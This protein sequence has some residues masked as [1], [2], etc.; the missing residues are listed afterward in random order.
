MLIGIVVT[1]NKFIAN[2]VVTGDKF[3]TSITENSGQGE[4]ASVKRFIAGGDTGDKHS[5][6]NLRE[7]CNNLNC[8]LKVP[9]R[10][11]FHRSD[12]PDFYT[13]KPLRVGNFGVKIKKIVKNI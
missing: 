12:F 4:I 1:T 13:I 7:F 5:F 10:E 2:V 9:K 11:I 8:F 3:F 6:A